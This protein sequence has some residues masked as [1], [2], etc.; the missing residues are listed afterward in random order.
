M[1]RLINWLPGLN[2]MEMPTSFKFAA[3][4]VL[5]FVVHFPV[6]TPPAFGSYGIEARP[7]EHQIRSIITLSHE[8]I[9][10]HFPPTLRKCRSVFFFCLLP[11]HDGS[12]YNLLGVKG[13]GWYVIRIFEGKREKYFLATEMLLADEIREK[14]FASTWDYWNISGY[15]SGSD[16]QWLSWWWESREVSNHQ[17]ITWI[18]RYWSMLKQNFKIFQDRQNFE[19]FTKSFSSFKRDFWFTGFSAYYHQLSLKKQRR[20]TRRATSKTQ[21]TK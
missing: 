18:C 9:S 12:G 1:L 4:A 15:F 7:S 21:S 8:I 2:A 20:T 16:T 6:R 5:A 13:P 11:F 3:I 14:F 17:P 19:P 10:D